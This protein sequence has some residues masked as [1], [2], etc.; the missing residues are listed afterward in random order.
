M[1][2]ICESETS[3]AKPSKPAWEIVSLTNLETAVVYVDLI[4]VDEITIKKYYVFI[5]QQVYYI[6]CG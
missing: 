2:S 1:R 4:A 3:F 5:L 6:L